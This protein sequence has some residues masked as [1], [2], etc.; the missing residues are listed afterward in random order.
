MHLTTL[1]YVRKGVAVVLVIVVQAPTKFGAR[2]EFLLK[3]GAASMG[4]AMDKTHT[5][6]P[7]L[8]RCKLRRI[9]YLSQREV[10][11][12]FVTIGGD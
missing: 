3:G 4:H 8:Y 11:I 12:R 2:K 10:D 6:F 9:R 7:L 5:E 1:E